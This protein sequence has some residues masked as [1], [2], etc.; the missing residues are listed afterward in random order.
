LILK[1]AFFHIDS[2]IF[3]NCSSAL[4]LYHAGRCYRVIQKRKKLSW[5]DAGNAC[6]DIKGELAFVQTISNDEH[7]FRLTLLLGGVIRNIQKSKSLVAVQSIR[8]NLARIVHSTFSCL[9][10]SVICSSNFTL[11][12]FHTCKRVFCCRTPYREP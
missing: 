7:F 3:W 2:K 10:R 9:F 4:W 12:S 6:K 5:L 8:H 11:V 1:C